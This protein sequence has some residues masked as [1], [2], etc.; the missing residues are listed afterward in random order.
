MG[1]IH[2]LETF[3][4]VD[5]PG[6][7]FVVFFQGCPMRCQYCHNPDTW[8]IEDGQEMGAEE[9]LSRFERNKTFYKTGGITATGGEPML[10]IDFLTE[11]FTKAKERGIHTCLDTSGIMFPGE[12]P[13]CADEAAAM[14]HKARMEQIDALLAVTDLV[15]LDIKHIESAAHKVLTGHANDNILAFARY[16]DAKKKPVWIRHVVVPGITFDKDELTVLGQFLKT[17]SNVEKL[18]V[19]PYHALGKVKYD[20]LGI[21]YV[22]KDTPQLSKAQAKE[23]EQMIKEAML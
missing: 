12:L 3:G 13:D 4:T 18:E 1:K 22:L 6:V 23:A 15:M 16:L 14:G 2:S 19:L 5:G 20:N 11:L 21:D 17:L 9:I 10:Q 7:R 8:H